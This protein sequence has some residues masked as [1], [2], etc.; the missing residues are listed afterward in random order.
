[1][2]LST[3]LELCE[4][5]MSEGNYLEAANLLK[6]IHQ[7]RDEDEDEDEG[8]EVIFGRDGDIYRSRQD[9]I[10]YN[11]LDN[12]NPSGYLKITQSEINIH[13]GEI[14][15]LTYGTCGSEYDED[16]QRI[17][18]PTMF[19]YTKRFKEYLEFYLTNLQTTS[20]KVDNKFKHST[21]NYTFKNFMNFYMKLIKDNDDISFIDKS[22]VLYTRLE[23]YHEI[24]IDYTLNIILKSL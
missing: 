3:I 10:I 22:D 20:I 13:T 6:N 19:I 17:N 16:I 18:E 14:I 11:G 12:D 21:N 4:E 1:M 7:E 24:F 2:D 5:H 23:D 9:I 15:S 8:V